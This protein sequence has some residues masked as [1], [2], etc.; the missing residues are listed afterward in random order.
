[1]AKAAKGNTPV[2]PNFKD[3]DK[4]AA[5]RAAAALAGGKQDPLKTPKDAKISIDKNGV[6]YT[7]W[8]ES[9]TITSAYRS[10]TKTGLMDVVVVAKI[11]QSEKNT[12]ARVFGHF[13]LNMGNEDLSEG[14]QIMNDRSNGAIIT[15]LTA[16]GFMPSG[17]ALKGS[18]LDKMFPSKGQPG[19][20][21]PLNGKSMIAN[22]V[23]QLAPQKDLKTGKPI[24]D[25]DDEPILEK[26]DNIESF[27]PETS[28]KDEDEEA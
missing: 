7:R 10:V 20:S 5:A 11:R 15:L 13:Y 14:H 21:S 18:L 8:N 27:L 2:A 22:I 26:R 12:G 23:Q 28:E 19:V 25:E 16:S 3:V 4:V 17:G 24:L 1:M 9:V 6:Q